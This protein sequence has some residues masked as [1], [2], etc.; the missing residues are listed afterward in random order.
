MAFA[1][2][3]IET[4]P[5]SE[6]SALPRS[7]RP[8]VIG[9][10]VL[11]ALVSLALWQVSKKPTRSVSGTNSNAVILVPDRMAAAQLERQSIANRKAAMRQAE[12]SALPSDRL[13]VTG[14]VPKI[15]EASTDFP[16]DDSTLPS[17][18]PGAGLPPMPITSG[19]GRDLLSVQ[20]AQFE[21]HAMELQKSQ[22]ELSRDALTSS[23]RVK[24]FEENRKESEREAMQM[25]QQMQS[26]QGGGSD[27][28]AFAAAAAPAL[29]MWRAGGGGGGGGGQGGMGSG[30]DS[31]VPGADPNMNAQKLAFF[32]SGGQ[33]LPPGRLDNTA[34][35]AQRSPY[36]VQM[37]S[38]IPGVLISGISSEAP[39]Q[40]IGQVSES[41]YD[42][43]RGRHLLIPQGS[44]LVGTYSAQ[45]SQGQ[46]RVQIAWVRV[47]FPNGGTVD[48]GGMAGADQ[49]GVAGFNDRVNRHFARRLAAALMASTITVAYEITAPTNGGLTEG[50]V[51]RGVGESLVQL[52][53][54]MARQEG[55]I[56]PTLEIRAGYRFNI[57]VQKDIT[58]PGPYED[59]INRDVRRRG[60]R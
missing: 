34:V 49:A 43:A 46:T 13:I 41:V 24:A 25:F 23:T 37:G 3:L 14:R 47:N 32:K 33:Q 9:F 29:A 58:F 45:V 20:Q 8:F 60:R 15:S 4:P 30:S 28:D 18:P 56:P 22:L 38:V 6:A 16:A 53:T 31:S 52:G 57:M 50:A 26:G 42:S 19:R 10:G 2:E 1:Q 39:G 5:R 55:Q 7:K 44:R 59:G 27:S 11:A 35:Q 54:D 12:A 40:I 17:A 51:H 21:A 48:L 36:E